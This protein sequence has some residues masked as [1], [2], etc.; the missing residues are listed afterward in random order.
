MTLAFA[1]TTPGPSLISPKGVGA[2]NNI[3]IITT[4]HIITI[5]GGDLMCLPDT[6]V[7]GIR[8]VL[9]FQYHKLS[10][11]SLITDLA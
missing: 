8:L 1:A 5:A 7:C 6:S 2:G 10:H 11:L 3:K 4:T 9:D